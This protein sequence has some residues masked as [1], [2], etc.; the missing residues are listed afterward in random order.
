MGSG[1]NYWGEL[2]SEK[3]GFVFI[4]IDAKVELQEKKS[5]AE[6][7]AEEGEDHFRNLETNV[8]RSFADKSNIIV[9][10]GGGTAC[11]NDNITW[12]NENGVSIYLQSAPENILERLVN[13]KEKRPLIRNLQN[14]ELLFYIREKIKERETFYHQARIILN[15]DDLTPD[16]IPDFLKK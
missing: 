15:V 8:L 6:I 1:K 16:Y 2:W 11:F 14:A 12:M 3:I 4:D 10:T 5:I 13:E 7:F 9:A